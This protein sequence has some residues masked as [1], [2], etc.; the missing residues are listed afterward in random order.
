[1]ESQVE[2][3][4]KSARFMKLLPAGADSALI[5]LKG[6]LLI[7]ELLTDLLKEKLAQ[8]NPL[9][10]KI[11]QNTMFAQKLNLCW[12]LVQK[13]IK[14]EIWPFLK[15]FNAIRNKMAHAVEPKCIDEKI[16]AFTE[17]VSSYDHYMMPKSR[18][19]DLEFSIAWLHIVLSQYLHH[20]KNL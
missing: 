4:E 2:L 14:L 18:G 15:E 7:E 12:A 5:V 20:V 10:I 16:E 13:D 1:M 3:A 9:E 8:G 6:H 11:G 19:S 17:M